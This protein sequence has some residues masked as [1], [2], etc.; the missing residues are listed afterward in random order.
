[1]IRGILIWVTIWWIQFLIAIFFFPW[2]LNCWYYYVVDRE[3]EVEI[4]IENQA[5]I[6]IGEIAVTGGESMI[7][8][9][10]TVTGIMT[11]IVDMIVNVTE[12]QSAPAI[13]IQEIV[14]DHVLGLENILGIM[15]TTGCYLPLCLAGCF[16]FSF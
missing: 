7:E 9:A 11:G 6:E 3:N 4:A 5:G 8:K 13:M 15:I 2:P 12:V 10:E 1:M 16:T 14:A